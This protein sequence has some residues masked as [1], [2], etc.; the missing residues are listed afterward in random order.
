[1]RLVFRVLSGR[2]PRAL[3]SECYRA[4]AH[5]A[6]GAQCGD[7]A[8]YDAGHDLQ[9]SLPCFLVLHND[10]PFKSVVK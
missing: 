10:N 5:A 4:V 6:G 1:M 7:D 9:D 3:Y 8:G 2:S